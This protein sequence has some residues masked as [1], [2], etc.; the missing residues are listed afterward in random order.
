MSVGSKR[1]VMYLTN[2]NCALIGKCQEALKEIFSRYDKDGDGALNEEEL[3][4]F[5]KG[6][7]GT[8]TGFSD[9]EK[10]EIKD[11][12]EIDNNNNLTLDGFMQMYSLQT[13]SEPSETWK[14]LET[15]GY[16]R[17]LELE[18]NEEKKE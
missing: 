12:F 13:L 8:T 7:N 10:E 4:N 6:C 3:D 2:K 15:H 5:A 17:Y 9:T 11:N 1:K 16:N 14:D 18:T